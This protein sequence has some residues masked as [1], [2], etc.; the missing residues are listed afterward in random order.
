[1][2]AITADSGLDVVDPMGVGDAGPG[3][4]GVEEVGGIVGPGG[5]AAKGDA[6]AMTGATTAADNG[7]QPV[8]LGR[9]TRE[10][11]HAHQTGLMTPVSPQGA[12]H[13]LS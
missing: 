11:V 1:M 9:T 8:R 4:V 12:E 13:G 6:V 5:A 7:R 3:V 10:P 2:G